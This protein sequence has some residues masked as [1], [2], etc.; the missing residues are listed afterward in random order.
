MADDGKIEVPDRGAECEVM[1]GYIGKGVWQVFKGIVNRIG[2]QGAPDVILIQSTGIALS[3]DKRLQGSHT[4]SWNDA[5]LGEI[6]TD[7][8]QTA[9]FKAKVHDDFTDV[10]VKRLMQ[11]IETD[12][13][14]L[15]AL[16]TR[17][18]GIIKSNGET[19]SVLPRDHI[20]RTDGR[21]LPTVDIVRDENT[22]YSWTSNKR[23]TYKSVITFYQDDD[24]GAIMAHIEGSGEPE[25]RLKTIYDSLSSATIAAKKELGI[26][27]SRQYTAN[28]TTAGVDVSAGSPL[29]L[30][31][32]RDIINGKYIATKVS[33][34]WGNGGYTVSIDAEKQ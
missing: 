31:G 9:G 34:N 16:S 26:L 32:F 8:I 12:V 27:N 20:E 15:Q 29:D 1:L 14:L 24:A 13:E 4:R 2:L 6:M 10:E 21:N 18:G 23:R 22:R 33:H 25:K 3:D 28:I 5:T 30:K 19:V 7:I 17:H 11:S